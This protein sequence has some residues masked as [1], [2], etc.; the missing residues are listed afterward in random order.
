MSG[1]AC[2]L[3]RKELLR[4]KALLAVAGVG[5]GALAAPAE[6]AGIPDS[7][8]AYLRDAVSNALDVYER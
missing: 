6:A 5:V 8:L 2:V 1:S 3:P 7:D 4:R